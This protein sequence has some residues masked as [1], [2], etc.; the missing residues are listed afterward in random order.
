[1]GK[2]EGDE[3]SFETPGGKRVLEIVEVE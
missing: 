2:E 3:V 1:L